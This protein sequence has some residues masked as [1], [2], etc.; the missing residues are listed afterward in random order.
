MFLE[1]QINS[2]ESKIYDHFKRPEIDVQ[3]GVVRYKFTCKYGGYVLTLP[4]CLKGRPGDLTF[5][6][7]SPTAAVL[8]R[9]RWDGSTGN[10]GRHVKNCDAAQVAAP[11]QGINDYAHGSSYTKGEFRYVL[12]LWIARRHR[13]H[14]IVKDPELVRAFKMLYSRVEIPSPTTVSRDIQEIFWISREHL[15][16]ILQVSSFTHAHYRGR[17]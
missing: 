6:L 8:Y 1:A 11:G 9:V 15:S 5:A 4:L 13:P 17:N 14:V 16:K 12:A 2:W 3:D 10:L 7:Y